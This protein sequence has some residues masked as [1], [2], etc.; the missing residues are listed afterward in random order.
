MVGR[1][2][3]DTSVWDG[4]IDVDALWEDGVRFVIAK[5]GGSDGGTYED[6]RFR[7]THTA[8]SLYGMHVGAYWYSAATTVMQA[9]EDARSCL[10]ILR[11]LE[12]QMPVFMDVETTEQQLL[13]VNSPRLLGEVVRAFCDEISN[14]GYRAGIYSW[15][16]VIDPISERVGPHDRWVC[17][18]T[19][20]VP[21]GR[22]D[23]WQFGGETNA[24]GDT[25]VAG[26]DPI[27]QDYSLTNYTNMGSWPKGDDDMPMECLISVKDRDT[28]VW[29]DG[30]NINDLTDTEDIDVLDDIHRGCTGSPMP[31]LTLS[32]QKF[33][34]LCQCIRGGYPAHLKDL[35][36]KYPPRSRE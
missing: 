14:A 5:V 34:R 25:G 15:K 19:E 11:G 6:P 27:D 18:W 24:L 30:A 26:Y 20:H 21:G 32:E 16:W 29:F 2:G 1:F 4:H 36:D 22:V 10:A 28:V 13:S 3:V 12:L 23:V 31:M 7:E 8:C 17:S 9:K 33:A 35:V